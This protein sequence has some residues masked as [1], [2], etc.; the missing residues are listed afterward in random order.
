M[1]GIG[2]ATTLKLAS[3]GADIVL[4]D[5]Q[6]AA[7]NLPPQE[8]AGNWRSIDKVEAIVQKFLLGALAHPGNW[9]S[10]DKVEAMATAWQETDKVSSALDSDDSPDAEK[11]AE[12]TGT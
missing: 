10:I 7:S 11:T 8:A 5:V 3:Q 4:S 1:K 9:R 12:Q 6:C 2:R